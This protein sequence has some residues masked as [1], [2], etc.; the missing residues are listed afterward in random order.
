MSETLFVG[1]TLS[2]VGG[3]FDG[4]T[5]F[6]RGGVFANAQTGNI[7][8]LGLSLANGNI[9]KALL[10][11]I[12][13]F[14]FMLGIIVSEVIRK[15]NQFHFLHWRQS[16][17]LLEILIV[18]AVTL[19]PSTN[20][21]SYTFD[22]IAN[23]LISFVCA[24]QVQTFRTIHGITC[25]TTMCTG[26]LRSS[27]DNI[28]QFS[29]THEKKF[30]KSAMKFTLINL[31]FIAGAVISAYITKIFNEKSVIFCG[32]GLLAVFALMFIQ[33]TEKK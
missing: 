13:I 24:L 22:M 26:N 30:L 33:P 16:I 3:Y 5:Y 15:N 27:I 21:S 20:Q 6:T 31:F 14:A 12:P 8:L 18:I 23:I 7:V 2:I 4:Y 19:M 28:V 17:I 32:F 10:Y 1:C 11:F 9:L 25:A 29:R